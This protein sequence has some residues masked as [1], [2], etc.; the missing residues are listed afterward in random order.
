MH[1]QSLLFYTLASTG[2]SDIEIIRNQ[3]GYVPTNVCRVSG[4]NQLS[5]PIVIQTYP[6]DGGAQRRQRKAR[7]N[8][9]DVG[10]PFPTLYWLTCPDIS[11]SIADLERKGFVK[12]IEEEIMQDKTLREQ[13]WVSHE[14]YAN[15]RWNLLTDEDRQSLT[16]RMA[17]MLRESGISGTNLTALVHMRDDQ[18]P[19]VKCLHSH[20]A[21]YRSGGISNPVGQRLHEILRQTFP[22]LIL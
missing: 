16:P 14:T 5:H 4:R 6:L 18:I 17:S 8:D 2:S 13:L 9:Q 11:R 12:K 21:Y 3:L 22:C 10:V 15:E 20:Y 1:W 19:S 7:R